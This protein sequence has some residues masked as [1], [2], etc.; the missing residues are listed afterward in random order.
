MIIPIRCFNCGKVLA[1]K[2]KLYK[3]LVEEEKM[4][5]EEALTF[6]G[7]NK[8]CSKTIFLT[9][10][11]IIDSLLKYDRYNHI[12]PPHMQYYH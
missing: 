4:T 2:W 7:L 3:K 10:V 11:D 5:E 8:Y 6:L 12:L 9:H 1:N